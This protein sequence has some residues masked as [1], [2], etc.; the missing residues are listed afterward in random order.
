MDKS[1]GQTTPEVSAEQLTALNGY[2]WKDS[3]VYSAGRVPVYMRTLV[4]EGPDVVWQKMEQEERYGK[5]F[6]GVEQYIV[7]TTH[8]VNMGIGDGELR[9]SLEETIAY[10]EDLRAGVPLQPADGTATAQAD[11]VKE[12]YGYEVGGSG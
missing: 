5:Y 2:G 4:N 6:W 9:N 1:G 7:P 12:Q 10:A 11:R 3:P 8:E